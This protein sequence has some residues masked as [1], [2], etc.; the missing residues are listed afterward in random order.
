MDYS[1]DQLDKLN[2]T[3]ASSMEGKYL[4]LELE[5]LIS[6]ITYCTDPEEIK[7]TLKRMS[8]FA[9]DNKQRI[10]D[11]LPYEILYRILYND[12]TEE[13]PLHINSQFKDIISWRVDRGI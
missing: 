3:L 2:V 12:S 13:F 7:E 4:G 11:D 9:R 10:E 1:K 6:L 5:H 8:D